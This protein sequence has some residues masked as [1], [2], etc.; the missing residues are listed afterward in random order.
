M[1]ESDKSKG[2]NKFLKN[3][4]KFNKF[5]SLTLLGRSTKWEPGG[6]NID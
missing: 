6:E 4:L 1:D 3:L 2:D 5:W